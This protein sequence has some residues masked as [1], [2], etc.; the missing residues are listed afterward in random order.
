M[1]EREPLS[2]QPEPPVKTW[3]AE[4]AGLLAP[5]AVRWKMVLIVTT[6]SGLA[7]ITGTLLMHNEYRASATMLLA[8]SNENSKFSS[9]GSL[10]SGD[11]GSLVGM[12]LGSSP[13]Q[14]IL[15]TMI[16]SNALRQ[17]AIKKF[18][19]VRVW[20]L[21]TTKALHWEDLA[22]IWGSK[23]N[24][25]IDEEDVIYINFESP[26]SVLSKQ[27]VDFAESWIDSSVQAFH[28]KRAEENAKFY[29]ERIQSE[30]SLLNEAQSNLI[31]YEGKYRIVQPESQ[32]IEA[33][34]LSSDLESTVKKMDLQIDLDSIQNGNESSSL[35][36][37]KEARRKTRQILDQLVSTGQEK[38]PTP[39]SSYVY[40]N[41]PATISLA[42]EYERLFQTV[43]LH[44]KA[45]M[46]LIQTN[47]ELNLEI[48]KNTPTLAIVDPALIPSRKSSPPRSI[49]VI[50]V[51]FLG[52]VLSCGYAWSLGYLKQN[53]VRPNKVIHWFK[54]GDW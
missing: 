34:K 16:P 40:K 42:S 6:L 36:G 35:K 54:T 2:I 45:L 29:A 21:D 48:R 38:S 24:A 46:L 15:K 12:K 52:F 44:K 41:I 31:A 50:V 5:I 3:L 9:L 51:T 17:D 30:D 32:L 8:T 26:D 43:E 11:L 18:H 23:F 25:G 47:E 53:G 20:K 19:L 27:V 39:G 14:E 4:M 22:K 13:D 1:S 37:M 49:I 28:H 7:S 10:M 33:L